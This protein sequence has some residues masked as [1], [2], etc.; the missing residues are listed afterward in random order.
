MQNGCV[1]LT[2]VQP[3]CG[4]RANGRLRRR[5]TT[6]DGDKFD[7]YQQAYDVPAAQNEIT[8]QFS[9]FYDFYE[10]RK[11]PMWVPFLHSCFDTNSR[12]Q[13]HLCTAADSL[14]RVPH[15]E[16]CERGQ[17]HRHPARRTR[18]RRLS[19]VGW[20]AFDFSVSGFVAILAAL[21]GSIESSECSSIGT[22]I[23]V[24]Q[25]SSETAAPPAMR[26]TPSATR[27]SAASDA[28]PN[29]SRARR[30]KSRELQ[31]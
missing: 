18:V 17:H 30:K 25:R 16:G 23:V 22:S 13:V 12:T 8:S 29:A 15:R 6:Q 2:F 4:V 14:V 31:L 20:A 24:A 9:D 11:L 1:T 27:D 26:A 19:P 3:S 28:A 21:S 10:R 5:G 7:F